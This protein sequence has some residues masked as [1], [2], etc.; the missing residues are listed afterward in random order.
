[1]APEKDGAIDTYNVCHGKCWQQ[2]NKN[3]A[4]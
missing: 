4:D 1:M 2:N 3:P